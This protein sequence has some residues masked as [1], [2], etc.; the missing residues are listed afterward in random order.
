MTIPGLIS[1]HIA[2]TMC[3]K[4]LHLPQGLYQQKRLHTALTTRKIKIPRNIPVL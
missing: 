4:I 3:R 2:K 1:S